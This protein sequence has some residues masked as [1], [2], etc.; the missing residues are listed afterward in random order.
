MKRPRK[1]VPRDRDPA[2][3]PGSSDAGIAPEWPHQTY[4]D[5]HT[6]VTPTSEDATTGKKAPEPG[7]L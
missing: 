2:K 4:A 1:H 5:E 6:A 7:D 3:V